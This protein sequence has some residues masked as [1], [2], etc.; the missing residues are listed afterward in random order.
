MNNLKN[1]LIALER[2]VV[3]GVP[4]DEPEIREIVEFLDN[5]TQEMSRNA[6]SEQSEPK[7]TLLSHL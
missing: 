1:S 6:S 7:I 3:E 5:E 4:K 2:H